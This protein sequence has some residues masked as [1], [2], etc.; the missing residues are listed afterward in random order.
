MVEYFTLADGF[1]LIPMTV[2]P[3]WA[4][5]IHPLIVHFPIGLLLAGAA[6]DSA[7]WVYR[8]NR[9]LR[10]VATILYVAGTI[11]LI[12]AYFTGRAAADTVWLPGMAHAA[13]KVHWDL[14]FRVVLFFSALTIVRLLLLWWQRPPGRAALGALAIAGLVGVVLIVEAADRGA[15][16]VYKHG[17]GIAR[18]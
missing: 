18:E 15:Q 4:P 17:V 14:A 8:C 10:F 9:S 7:A 5:N 1:A 12:A 11:S 13:V 6:L 3:D 16:L 2:L